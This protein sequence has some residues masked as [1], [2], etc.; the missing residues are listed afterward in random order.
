LHICATYSVLLTLDK[1]WWGPQLCS[2]GRVTT[3]CWLVIAFLPGYQPGSG[4]MYQITYLP[5]L[6][7]RNTWVGTYLAQYELFQY[8]LIPYW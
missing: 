1:R 8:P 2:K 5:G 3:K 6:R 7:F 4:S